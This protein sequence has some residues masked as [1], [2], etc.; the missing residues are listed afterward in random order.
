[1]S[2]T[3]WFCR[4]YRREVAEHKQR[5]KEGTARDCFALQFLKNPET[6]KL[7]ETQTLFALG[8]LLEAGSDTS[9]MMISILLAAAATDKRWV[10]TA[11]A[12]LDSVCGEKGERLPE[13][14]DRP[15]LRY[16]TA[17]VKEA[18]RWRPFAEIG[19]PHMLTQ[20]DEYEGYKFPAGTLFTW[21]ALHISLNPDEYEDP[22][23]FWPERFLNEDLDSVLKGHWSFGPGE[24]ILISGSL[25]TC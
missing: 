1:M 7:G 23:R 6:T 17:T 3:D 5:E 13:F 2:N 15:D 12:N 10:R 8:S 25:N 20:D 16:I 24:K 22:E 18:L 9:R 4:V 19:V 21:S 14:S 11:R